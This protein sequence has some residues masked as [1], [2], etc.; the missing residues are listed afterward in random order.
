MSLDNRSVAL[1]GCHVTA[2]PRA[3]AC[4]QGG[5][6]HPELAG[7]AEHHNR[8]PP[9]QWLQI[10]EWLSLSPSIFQPYFLV[11]VRGVLELVP[12]SMGHKAGGHH[13]QDAKAHCQTYTL[14]CD[15]GMPINLAS[16]EEMNTT[17]IQNMQ[18]PHM[19]NNLRSQGATIPSPSS[20][21]SPINHHALG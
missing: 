3:L 15:I 13:G 16:R 1:P 7:T 14:T 11:K 4:R 20:R 19:E 2:G 10:K 8:C 12:A 18:N 21:A 17:H 9:P 5:L 6:G